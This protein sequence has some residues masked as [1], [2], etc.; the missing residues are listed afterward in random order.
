M[1]F[2]LFLGLA[3]YF[4]TREEGKAVNDD[5]PFRYNYKQGILKGEVSQYR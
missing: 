5:V 3:G 1:F 4:H 2:G